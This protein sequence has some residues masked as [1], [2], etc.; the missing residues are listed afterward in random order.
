MLS[1]LTA[2]MRTLQETGLLRYFELAPSRYRA[3]LTCWTFGRGRVESL[4]FNLPARRIDVHGFDEA[5]T[6]EVFLDH[7]PIRG[8]MITHAATAAELLACA[9]ASTREPGQRAEGRVRTVPGCLKVSV[10]ERD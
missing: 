2:Y 3:Q 8:L 5:K 4:L 10:I 7:S 6:A 1:M 9:Y